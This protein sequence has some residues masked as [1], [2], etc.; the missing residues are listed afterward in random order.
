MS[1]FPE[2]SA[3]LHVIASKLRFTQFAM[4]PWWDFPIE[5]GMQSEWGGLCDEKVDSS[6]K[7]SNGKE[8]SRGSHLVSF[9]MEKNMHQCSSVEM[10]SF[11]KP[12]NQNSTIMNDLG[13]HASTWEIYSLLVLGH[14]KVAFL[15]EINLACH[16]TAIDEMICFMGQLAWKWDNVKQERSQ[17]CLS[18]MCCCS[19][20]VQCR[21]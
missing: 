19:F 20:Q 8:H 14:D 4:T 12:C 3:N 18:R 6:L 13:K 17:Q 16:W 15:C 7:R 1:W 10:L 5:T 11:V 9:A 2:H 21:A